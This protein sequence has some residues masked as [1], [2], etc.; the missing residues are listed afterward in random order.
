[1][2]EKDKKMKEKEENKELLKKNKAKD[3]EGEGKWSFKRIYGL[4]TGEKAFC[5]NKLLSIIQKNIF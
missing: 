1:M 3:D 2:C 5:N 4:E